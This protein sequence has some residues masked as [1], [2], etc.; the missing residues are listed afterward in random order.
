MISII[1]DGRPLVEVLANGALTRG[2]LRWNYRPIFPDIYIPKLTERTLDVM[3]V[4]AWLWSERRSTITGRAAAA[5]QARNGSTGRAD[6]DALAKQSLSARHHR[7]R[8]AHA[9]TVSLAQPSRRLARHLPGATSPTSTVARHA[10]A[11]GLVRA[12]PGRG[13]KRA[14]RLIDMMDAGAESPGTWLRRLISAGSHA[15]HP[16]PGRR[17]A[18][19]TST[20]VGNRWSPSNTTATTTAWTAR[21]YVK[22]IRRAEVLDQLGWRVVRVI[23]E[24]RPRDIVRTGLAG[25]RSTWLQHQRRETEAWVAGPRNPLPQFCFAPG[26]ATL[27]QL[28][29]VAQLRRVGDVAAFAFPRR[30]PAST[31]GARPAGDDHV[32]RQQPVAPCTPVRPAVRVEDE[33]VVNINSHTTTVTASRD[34]GISVA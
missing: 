12:I 34:N 10:N 2:Q 31:A 26:S 19:P 25:F 1:A 17:P 23:K 32:S 14:R 27:G 7:P 8:R 20:W 11:A 9:Q 15:H 5:L 30:V 18:W 6:R 13:N 4:G 29:R 16:D 24:D 3:T 28:A 33:V 22:D 21:Q